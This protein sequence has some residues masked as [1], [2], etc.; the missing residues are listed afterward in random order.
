MLFITKNHTF[1]FSGPGHDLGQWVAF[2]SHVYL[3]FNTNQFFTL[4]FVFHDL[5]TCEAYRKF[6]SP[7]VPQFC[8]RFPG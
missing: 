1:F 2:G 3:F 5:D 7:N 4:F 8:L 6:V